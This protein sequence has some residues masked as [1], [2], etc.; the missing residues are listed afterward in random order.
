[1]PPG[2]NAVSFLRIYSSIKG[3]LKA[4]PKSPH[5]RE[6]YS[7]L[8]YLKW[9]RRLPCPEGEPARGVWVDRLCNG[10]LQLDQKTKNQS[11]Q[12]KQNHK[13]RRETY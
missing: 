2:K 13:I 6:K 1:M 9:L 5:F 11:I 8:S 12:L 10:L 4:C 3:F 7:V